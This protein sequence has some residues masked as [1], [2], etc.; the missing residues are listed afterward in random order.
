MRIKDVID[1]QTL[2]YKWDVIEQIPE[3]AVLKECEQSAKWHSEGNVWNHTKLVCDAAVKICESLKQHNTTFAKY[4]LTAALFHDIGKGTTTIFKKDDWHSYGHEIA[5]DKLTRK[6]LWDEG[7]EVREAICGLVRWHMEPLFMFTH[8]HYYERIIDLS[9]NIVSWDLLINLKKCDIL[10]SKPSDT[11]RTN[12]DLT[13]LE[14]LVTITS[15]LN[16]YY[17][18]SSI[19]YTRQL[20]YKTLEHKKTLNV[21]ILIGLPGAGKSTAVEKIINSFKG[22]YTV[23]SRDIAR[24]E[25]GFC[26]EGEKMV[27]TNEQEKLVTEKCNEMIS[28]AADFGGTIIIDNTNLKRKYRESYISL[29]SN[30]NLIIT[31]DYVETKTLENNLKRREGQ[32]DKKVFDNM[33]MGFEWPQADEYDYFKIHLN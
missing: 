7:Y 20:R 18:K 25:L 21:H 30:Y 23:I 15:K 26:K 29:L 19:P 12:C 27:G 6:L 4:L 1:I 3:F 9:K 13:I 5:S 31:Y 14:D 2:T 32:I 16:C 28:M 8:K 33:I 10:G 22:P 24:Y 11:E 17:G